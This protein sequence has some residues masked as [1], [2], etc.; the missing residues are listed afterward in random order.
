[1]YFIDFYCFL[2]M[3]IIFLVSQNLSYEAKHYPT[4]YNSF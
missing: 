4:S 3:F 2:S 1:M